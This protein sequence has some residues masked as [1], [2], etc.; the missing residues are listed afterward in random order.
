M[1]PHDAKRLE[2]PPRGPECE[3]C[4]AP[5]WKTE[6]RLIHDTPSGPATLCCEECFP[7]SD[8]GPCWD[9][10]PLPEEC[11]PEE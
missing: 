11:T 8:T 4:G 3:Y 6:L 10:C 2:G 9:D 1:T 7:A 5:E